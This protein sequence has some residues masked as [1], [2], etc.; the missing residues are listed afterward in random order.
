M[1]HKGLIPYA[2]AA[3]IPFIFAGNAQSQ[4]DE[5]PQMDH[6]IAAAVVLTEFMNLCMTIM[7]SGNTIIGTGSLNLIVL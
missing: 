3:N 2:P 1:H 4:A 6:T 5:G 7:T